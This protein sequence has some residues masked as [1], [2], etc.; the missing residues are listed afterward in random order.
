M[1][2]HGIELN[3]R[4]TGE[5]PV[6]VWAHGLLTDMVFEDEIGWLDWDELAA[7]LT[8]V[9]YDM[10]G[11]G[12]SQFTRD[13]AAYTWQSHAEDLIGVADAL[14]LDRF[15][16]GG[17]SMGAAA[18]LLAALAV[19]KRVAALVLMTPPAAWERRVGQAELY[20]QLV[21]LVQD[22]GPSAYVDLMGRQ[23]RLKG[24]QYR[25]SSG[26]RQAYLRALERIQAPAV[27]S[28]LAGAQQSDLP[29][30]EALRTLEMPVLICGWENDPAHPVEMLS[31]LKELLPRAAVMVA[32]DAH[33]LRHW[34][35]DVTDF[36][37]SFL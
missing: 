5:G 16:A 19:P 6:L 13:A 3:T 31:E 24:W 11:H 7:S 28:I 23:A 18:A 12:R 32:D 20:R 9:R 14:G 22:R 10:R 25:D 37:N 29:A 1:K 33:G 27:R 17:Q 34:T 30:K 15:V 36:L 21:K 4:V 2:V 26:N 35:T 8:L